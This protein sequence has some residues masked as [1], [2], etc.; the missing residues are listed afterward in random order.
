MKNIV[1]LNK[2]TLFTKT[3]K[4]NRTFLLL[5]LFTSDQNVSTTSSKKWV[6]LK[7]IKFCSSLNQP[8]KNKIQ[9]QRSYFCA[10][11]V[12]SSSKIYQNTF[13]AV[14]GV[15]YQKTVEKQKELKMPDWLSEVI[16]VFFQYLQKKAGGLKKHRKYS[17][18]SLIKLINRY[19]KTI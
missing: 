2:A 9:S 6:H 11:A 8:K 15:E 19:R 10:G 12:K 13:I 16:K 5:I 4:W 14:N 7:M 1:S 18:I 3:V 17:C